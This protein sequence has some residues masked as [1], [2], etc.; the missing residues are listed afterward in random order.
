MKIVYYFTD[1]LANKLE[2]YQKYRFVDRAATGETSPCSNFN[3]LVHTLSTCCVLFWRLALW[4]VLKNLPFW[5]MFLTCKLCHIKG[6]Q[7]YV[8]STHSANLKHVSEW[9]IFRTARIYLHTTDTLT[10]L[11]LPLEYETDSFLNVKPNSTT[12]KTYCLHLYPRCRL[13]VSPYR[14]T[15]K[16]RNYVTMPSKRLKK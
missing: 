8:F 5:N 16:S 6:R 15:D 11:I 4:A 9:H 7:Q 14:S 12:T 1:T 2:E 10:A 3:P 13:C